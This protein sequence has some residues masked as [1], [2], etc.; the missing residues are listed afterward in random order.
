MV[1][2]VVVESSFRSSSVC[3]WFVVFSY[4]CVISVYS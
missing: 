4:P 1:V 3:S 2:V